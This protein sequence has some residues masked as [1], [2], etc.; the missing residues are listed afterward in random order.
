MSTCSKNWLLGH[1]ANYAA[2]GLF[3]VFDQW[4]AEYGSVFWREGAFGGG[5]I[6][7]A[8]PKA[9]SHVFSHSDVSCLTPR[10]LERVLIKRRTSTTCIPS[11]RAQL[12]TWCVMPS[13]YARRWC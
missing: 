8:D 2:P 3:Q 1:H 5:E 4:L 7:L 6:F 11:R 13:M 9:L 10:R 12:R